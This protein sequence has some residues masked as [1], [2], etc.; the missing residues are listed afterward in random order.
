[1]CVHR[2][3]P[4]R[5]KEGQQSSVTLSGCVKCSGVTTPAAGG[6]GVEWRA[7]AQIPT[8]RVRGYSALPKYPGLVDLDPK[9][10]LEGRMWR[11][12]MGTLSAREKKNNA[13][14]RPLTDGRR[15]PKAGVVLEAGC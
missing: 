13:N 10:T 6:S 1:V 12:E 2:E 4:C 8:P 7:V 11:R 5:D 15:G 3:P 14:N 9:K